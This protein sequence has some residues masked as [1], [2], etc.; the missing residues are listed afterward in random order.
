MKIGDPPASLTPT[1]VH[2]PADLTSAVHAPAGLTIAVQASYAVPT[3]FGHSMGALPPC[4]ASNASTPSFSLTN[5]VAPC[6]PFALLRP[7]ALLRPRA[8]PPRLRPSPAK[9]CR[10]KVHRVR[11][12]RPSVQV[13]RARHCVAAGRAR[14]R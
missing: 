3:T 8:L 10:T 2:A 9:P 11:A 1:A 6:H 12:V 14:P 13:S 7:C 4:K 5:A